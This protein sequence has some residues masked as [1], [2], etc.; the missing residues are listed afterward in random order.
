MKVDRGK[1]TGVDTTKGVVSSNKVAVA[2]AGNSSVIAQMAKIKL[3][4]ETHPLQAWVTEP[5]KP[6]LCLL[7]TSPSPRD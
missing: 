6:C 3:P 1:I 2:V 7:Y 4:I 5:I